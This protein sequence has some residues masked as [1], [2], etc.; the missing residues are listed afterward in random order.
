M[1]LL[2]AGLL[3]KF[4]GV[5]LQKAQ[6]I[7]VWAL[8]GIGAIVLVVVFGLV[9]RSCNKPPKLDQKEIIKAQQAIEANDRKVMVEILTNS[10]V[11]EQGIDN[12]IK[13]AENATAQAKQ[14]YQGKSNQE[15]ADELER[16]ANQ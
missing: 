15:L 7:V 3:T 12:S 6:R 1:I 11:R 5:D 8:L 14:S 16:R 2:I 4:F 9:Y 13:A 10:D